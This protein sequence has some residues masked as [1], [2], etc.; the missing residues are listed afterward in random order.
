MEKGEGGAPHGRVVQVR[1]QE[2]AVVQA[3]RSVEGG[4][5]A[6]E[7]E[8]EAAAAAVDRLPVSGGGREVRLEVR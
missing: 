3:G 2:L 6:E 1:P 7:K 4:P 5:I 8:E